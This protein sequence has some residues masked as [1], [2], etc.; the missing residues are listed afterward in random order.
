LP[1]RAPSLE[2]SGDLRPSLCAGACRHLP[3]F[4]AP[5][6]QEKG[7]VREGEL[8]TN[9]GQSI[10]A[11]DTCRRPSIQSWDITTLAGKRW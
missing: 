9:R 10:L 7:N 1:D 6:G 4:G 5:K 2:E 3:L 11:M 8:Q